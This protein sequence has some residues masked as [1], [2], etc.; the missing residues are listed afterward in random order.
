MC[1]TLLVN[2]QLRTTNSTLLKRPGAG[3][4]WLGFICKRACSWQKAIWSCRPAR[5]WSGHHDQ[6]IAPAHDQEWCA[7]SEESFHEDDL[8]PRLCQ[9]L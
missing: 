2:R 3:R 9:N 6:T 7:S 5:P 4:L 8:Q 1:C